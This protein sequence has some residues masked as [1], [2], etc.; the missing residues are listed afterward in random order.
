M[1]LCISNQIVGQMSAKVLEKHYV[2]RY[3]FHSH[4]YYLLM[5]LKRNFVKIL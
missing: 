5:L 2:I 4:Y 1:R 3:G